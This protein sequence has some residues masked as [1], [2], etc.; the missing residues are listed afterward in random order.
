MAVWQYNIFIVPEEEVKSFFGDKSYISFEDLNGVNFWK[1][2]KI[3]TEDFNVFEEVLPRKRSWSNDI[4]LFGD[5]SSNCLEILINENKI[6]EITARIDLRCDYEFFLKFLCDFSLKN[7]FVF[8][9]N[10]LKVLYPDYNI[11]NKEINDYPIYKSF[12][13]TIEK[14]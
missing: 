11:M 13:S 3:D 14:P 10:S 2:Q 4:V 5:E 12:L 8:L 6:E 1:Y 7:D 9:D